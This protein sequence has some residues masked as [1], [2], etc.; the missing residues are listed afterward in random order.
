[1]YSQNDE[2]RIILEHIGELPPGRFLD[3]GAYDGK[4]FSNTLRLVELGWGG[5]CFEP[6]PTVFPHLQ[7]LHEGR[8]NVVC[9]PKAVSDATGFTTFFDSGGDAISTTEMSHRRKWERGYRCKFTNVTVPTVSID[10]M[11]AEHGTDFGFLNLDVESANL[12]LF[13]LMPWE[14]L[15]RLRLICVEHDGAEGR[16]VAHVAGLGFRR[17]G[18]TGENILLYR[19]LP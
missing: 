9:V 14:R 2:E 11:L 4:T 16:M 7:K 5:V 12:H 3:I 1:M 19:E 8:D 13:T 15:D 6:S 17:V 18:F 10:D